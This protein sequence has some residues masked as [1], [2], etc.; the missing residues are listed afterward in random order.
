MKS[1]IVLVSNPDDIVQDGFR[2]LL[3]DLNKDQSELFSRCLLDLDLDE[4]IVVYTWSQ[5]DELDWL[6]D[7][8]LKSQIIIF[9]AESYFQDLIGY[10]CSKKN[11]YYFGHLK[12]LKKINNSAIYDIEQLKEI[13][14][15][16]INLYGKTK[17]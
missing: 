15:E 6:F 12:S 9:N 4:K 1:S 3:V 11:S 8:Q 2:I 17:R 5:N 13:L 10:F 7:K 16:S 14:I